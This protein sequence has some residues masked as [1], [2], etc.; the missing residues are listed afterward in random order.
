MTI[1]DINDKKREVVAVYI[2]SAYPEFVEALF[3]NGHV[4]WYQKPIFEDR[5]PDVLVDLK[6][7]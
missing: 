7:I 3:E 4:E 5:N 6:I 2:N 1:I